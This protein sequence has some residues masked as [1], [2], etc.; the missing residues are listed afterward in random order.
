MSCYYNRLKNSFYGDNPYSATLLQ[1]MWH[2][3]NTCHL[4]C[5]LCF[6]KA[7]RTNGAELTTYQIE[8]TINLL[9]RL[10]VKKVDLSGG[11]PL[12][13]PQL[14]FISSCCND[15]GIVPTITTSGFGTET[16][17]NW[18]A[19]NYE[20][21]SRVI[22][23]LDGPSFVHN[24]L[25][26]SDK[27]FD[28]LTE[29]YRRLSE[30]HC[31]RIR[32]NTVVSRPV[33]SYTNELSKIINQLSPVEWCCIQPHP[34]NKAD[35]FSIFSPTKKEFEDFV[36]QSQ[37]ALKSSAIS[38]LTRN[39]TDYSSYWILYPNQHICHLTTDNKFDEDFV[40]LSD[41]I[42]SIEEAVRKHPQLYVK[43]APNEQSTTTGYSRLDSEA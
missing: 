1:V 14:P 22:V 19:N 13:C 10:G 37:I 12:L 9:K 29:F 2:I 34:I 7:L 24:S 26:G 38:I 8:E 23:S 41:N 20:L 15:A 25:R 33:L 32:I 42:P 28:K 39:N 35:N 30:K 16:N 3:T 4:D 5:K 6:S 36:E 31:D 21:F 18:V 17:I 43:L 40:L 27:A 11:E